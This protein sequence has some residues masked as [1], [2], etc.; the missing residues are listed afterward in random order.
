[1]PAPPGH[2]R[3]PVGKV[4]AWAGRILVGLVALVIVLVVVA[5]VVVDLPW[6]RRLAA[7]DLTA[8]LAPQFKE[9]IVVDAIGSLTLGG[10]EGVDAHIDAADGTRVVAARGVT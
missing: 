3:G 2:P 4:F 8:L 9:K 6:G 1:R 5:L 10:V 7:R